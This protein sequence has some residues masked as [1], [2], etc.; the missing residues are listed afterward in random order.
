MILA[1]RAPIAG[2]YDYSAFTQAGEP[3]VLRFG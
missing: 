3:R 1:Q 2:A